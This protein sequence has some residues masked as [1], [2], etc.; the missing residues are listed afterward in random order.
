M[1]SRTATVV[2]VSSDSAPGRTYRVWVGA[3]GPIFCDCPGHKYRHE[4]V[5]LRPPCKHM[6]RLGADADVL[7]E[8]KA[9]A[10]TPRTARPRRQP[11]GR[12]AFLEVQEQTDSG[13]WVTVTDLRFSNLEVM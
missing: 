4:P 3:D 2:E 12:F 9:L 10:T 13:A 8:A 1:T 7:A 6:R 11:R 5:E